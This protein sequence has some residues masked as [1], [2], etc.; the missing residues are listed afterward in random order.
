MFADA[1]LCNQGQDRS[2]DKGPRQ[3]LVRVG[4]D[5]DASCCDWEEL[6]YVTARSVRRGR[7]NC[8]DWWN[9]YARICSPDTL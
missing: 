8:E 4:D 2:A 3:S 9:I 5:G 7:A 6:S 1:K